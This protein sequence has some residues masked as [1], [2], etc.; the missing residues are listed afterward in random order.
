MFQNALEL[1]SAVAQQVQQLSVQLATMQDEVRKLCQRQED[2][3]KAVS[4]LASHIPAMHEDIRDC[5]KILGEINSNKSSSSSFGSFP[6]GFVVRPVSVVAVPASISPQLRSGNSAQSVATTNLSRMERTVISAPPAYCAPSFATSSAT[7][8]AT[9]PAALPQ[10][11]STSSPS[12]TPTSS[13]QQNSPPNTSV[14]SAQL[15]SRTTSTSSID[16]VKSSDQLLSRLESMLQS[17]TFTSFENLREQVERFAVPAGF[18]V[19]QKKYSHRPGTL[20]TTRRR[21]GT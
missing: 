18:T 13:R 21:G 7:L 20:R 2:T 9:L 5:N 6:P 16:M 10:P 12:S 3:T 14:R 1:M 15:Q 17:T 19:N 11:T 4:V 8:P